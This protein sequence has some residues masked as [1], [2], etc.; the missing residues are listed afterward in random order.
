MS[1]NSDHHIRVEHTDGVATIRFTRPSKHNAASGQLLL[2]T[3]EALYRLESDDSVGAIVLTGEGAVFSAGFDLEEVP[4]G[5]A[6]EIQS[7][8]RLKALYYHAVIHM[9]ARIEKPTLAAIN[10]PAVGGGLGMSLACDLAVCTDR[11]TFL[12]AWMSIGIANDASSSFYLPRIVGYRRAMEWLL[13]NRTL[14]ADEAYEWGV[15]NRV[16]SEAD[17]QSRVDEIARQLAAA[18]THLQGLVKNRIQEGSSEALES[19]TEHEVQNVIASVG[20]PHFA[21]RLA[22]FR[23]KEMRSSALAV[24]L[25]AVCGGQ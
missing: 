14:A 11:A 6:S 23:S 24:D 10:G 17:F 5:P 18:P 4:M 3:L 15:V 7:H 12:P 21:E 19:C 2:E 20:H 1:S 13:T 9:L 8:F 25:D 22:M 16:F